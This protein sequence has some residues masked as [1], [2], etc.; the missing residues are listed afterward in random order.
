M[1]GTHEA[2][3]LEA[4]LASPTENGGYKL[5]D[6]QVGAAALTGKWFL[7]IQRRLDRE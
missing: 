2:R 4:M 7:K 6:L 5:C 3:W 1:A